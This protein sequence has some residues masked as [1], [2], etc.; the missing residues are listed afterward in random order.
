MT[1]NE[2]KQPFDGEVTF[3]CPKCHRPVTW[4][5]VKFTN[6]SSMTFMDWE[7]KHCGSDVLQLS[8]SR[9]GYIAEE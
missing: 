1:E 7:C 3:V 8:A 9:R 5:E 6:G 4:T 2:T